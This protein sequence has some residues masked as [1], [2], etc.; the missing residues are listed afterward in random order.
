MRARD[1]HRAHLLLAR[2]RGRTALAVERLLDMLSS[3]N[4]SA[5]RLPAPVNGPGSAMHA[6]GVVRP[7]SIAGPGG[8]APASAAIQAELQD[9][10]RRIVAEAPRRSCAG[11]DRGYERS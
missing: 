5:E 11:F 4:G 2:F 7:R 9:K 6:H 3:I 1:D 8:H 10:V